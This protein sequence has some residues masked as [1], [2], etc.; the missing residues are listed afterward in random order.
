MT[1]TLSIG[2]SYNNRLVNFLSIFCGASVQPLTSAGSPANL[3]RGSHG[4]DHRAD[5]AGRR[6]RHADAEPPE[7]RTRSTWRCE[8]SWRERSAASRPTAPCESRPDRRREHFCAGG[9]VKDAG[10]PAVGGRGPQRVEA[11]N[12]AIPALARFR[13]PTI[14]RVDGYAVEPGATSR[15]PAT[16]VASTARASARCSRD[17]SVPRRRRQLPAARADWPAKGARVHGGHPRCRRG[18]ADRSGEPGRAG[19]RAERR[20]LA[21]ARRIADGPPRATRCQ[22]LLDR[23]LAVDL[24]TSLAWEA[25]SQGLMIESEDHREGL[26]A[27]FR[28][29]R[30]LHGPVTDR[31]RAHYDTRFLPGQCSERNSTVG[32]SRRSERRI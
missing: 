10:G 28:S 8:R 29:A 26:A 27:F 22:S 19:R 6:D 7:V 30:A 14:A 16:W 24:E 17:R 32:G 4:R 23:S 2:I 18:G 3:E 5:R 11:V 13:T 25:L 31:P 20:D 15:S 1:R 21:L 9:D 12:R